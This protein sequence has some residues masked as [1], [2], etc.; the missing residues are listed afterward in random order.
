MSFSADVGGNCS[1][2]KKSL[3]GAS[4]QKDEGESKV[5]DIRNALINRPTPK[6]IKSRCIVSDILGS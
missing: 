5:K 1:V 4:V 2:S 6:Y 3:R